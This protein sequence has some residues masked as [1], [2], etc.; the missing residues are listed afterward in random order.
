MSTACGDERQISDH[1]DAS[2]RARVR[3]VPSLRC[4]RENFQAATARFLRYGYKMC[5]HFCLPGLPHALLR[6]HSRRA[7]HPRAS[8]FATSYTRAHTRAVAFVSGTNTAPRQRAAQR[9][10]KTSAVA[11]KWS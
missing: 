1:T 4:T 3:L 8:C 11:D 5:V 10:A 9:L 6:F 7:A 2:R